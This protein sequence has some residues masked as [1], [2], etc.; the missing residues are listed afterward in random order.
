LYDY[1]VTV[2]RYS[3]KYCSNSRTVSFFPYFPLSIS[4]STRFEVSVRGTAGSELSKSGE[5]YI[6]PREI[7]GINRAPRWPKRTRVRA[8][9]V[10]RAPTKPGVLGYP[11]RMFSVSCAG[12]SRPPAPVPG[13]LSY[14]DR[15]FSVSCAGRSRPP[16]P[17]PGVLGYPDR[18]FSVSCAGCSRPPA[19]VPDVLGYPDRV[20]SVFCAGRSRP[21]APVP[22]VLDYPDRVFSVS[23]AGRSRPPAPNRV[24]SVSRAGCSRL[25]DLDQGIS[26]PGERV[27]PRRISPGLQRGQLT[28]ISL[29]FQ[30]LHP[31]GEHRPRNLDRTRPLSTAR[32][33]SRFPP[34]RSPDYLDL[35]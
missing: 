23:C 34:Q 19:P 35:S 3:G 24:F 22:G 30:T 2:V 8:S 7:V 6:I 5:K 11:N 15:V 26:V 4:P 1:T 20:F 13:V 17:V 28:M 18:V 27:T 33:T 21:P 16:V 32:L 14:P 29:Q 25:P 31:L 9:G 12:R 10:L